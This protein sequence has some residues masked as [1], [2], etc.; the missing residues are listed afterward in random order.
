MPWKA[1]HMCS[2]NCYGRRL[3]SVQKSVLLYMQVK[4]LFLAVCCS[5]RIF[6]DM[7]CV[8]TTKTDLRIMSESGQNYG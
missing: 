1:T 4:D 3:S 2:D 5:S 6:P 7:A 8:R